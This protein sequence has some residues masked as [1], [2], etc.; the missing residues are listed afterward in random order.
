MEK[1]KKPAKDKNKIPKQP[2]DNPS[3]VDSDQQPDQTPQNQPDQSDNS[4]RQSWPFNGSISQVDTDAIDP[5]LID[6]N[7]DL[8]DTNKSVT[9]QRV[10]PS[11]KTDTRRNAKSK[12]DAGGSR[13]SAKVKKN[14]NYPF[15]T[16][17]LNI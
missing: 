13:R 10:V 14:Q 9:V 3:A 12:T 11:K 6:V 15:S 4:E 16:T 5:D 8:I 2:E 1:D 17:T 7:S